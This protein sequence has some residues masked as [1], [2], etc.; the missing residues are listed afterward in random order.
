MNQRA[1]GVTQAFRYDALDARGRKT[2]G[3][4]DAVNKNEVLTFVRAKGWHP[5]EVTS[6]APGPSQ[7]SRPSP[8][9]GASPS[10]LSSGKLSTVQ[11]NSGQSRTQSLVLKPKLQ[12]QL[13]R[14]LG[15]MVSAGLPLDR[16][17]TII[18]SSEATPHVAAA[19]NA[20]SIALRRGASPSTAF[21]EAGAFD[22]AFLAMIKSGE[23]SGQLG[24]TLLEIERLM[25]QQQQLK[26]RIRSALLYPAIL[27]IVA[28]VSVLM[29]LLVV[30]PKFEPVI[31]PHRD[32]LPLPA[33]I[34]FGLSE[35][36][37]A[38]GWLLGLGAAALTMA[39][40]QAARAGTL[41]PASVK[42][43]SR[44]PGL[45]G[46]FQSSQVSRTCRSLGS[47]LARN[48]LLLNAMELVADN[49]QAESTRA[50]LRTIQDRLR[51]GV[52]LSLAM[53]ETGAFPPL[54][55]QLIAVGEETGELP[56]ML[57]RAADLLDEDIDSATKRFLIIFE[58]A[59]LVGIG[60][61]VG[62][63]LYGLFSAILS[64]NEAVG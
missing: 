2:S 11:R 8:S 4:I 35:F 18:A 55:L 13:V 9:A 38:Y 23:S 45:S 12:L 24:A 46:L 43:F 34:V 58:P 29:I 27:L 52:P 7:T 48:V 61:L 25:G 42:L 56:K 40:V 60:I 21:A 33:Q 15:Q 26:A 39:A 10:N 54:T 20:I 22:G 36:V 19:A 30:I 62:G 57:T 16:A 49:G 5:I 41:E 47:L 59:L 28:L 37:Q 64:I 51:S 14:Q 53:R 32:S 17:M 6:A 50:A 3:V 44:L 1:H 63:L 31:G